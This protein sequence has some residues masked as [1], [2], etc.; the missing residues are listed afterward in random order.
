MSDIFK[1]LDKM[2][3]EDYGYVDTLSDEEVKK[4]SPYVLQMWCHGAKKNTAAHVFMTDLYVN[5]YV[6]SLSKHPRLLLKLF[7]SANG[8]MDST[9]YGF[10]KTTSSEKVSVFKKIS[11]YYRVSYRVAKQYH[12][13][14]DPQEL[15]DI[16][17]SMESK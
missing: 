9:R 11:E 4:L 2:N 7:M 5:E 16:I 1:F 15:K 6:F 13:V 8:G 17:D 3:D 12:D 10:V 14:M